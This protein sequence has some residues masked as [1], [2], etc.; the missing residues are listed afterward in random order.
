MPISWS[1][2]L[3]MMTFDIVHTKDD[4]Q[5]RWNNHLHLPVSPPGLVKHSLTVAS[6]LAACV[7][8]VGLLLASL[9]GRALKEGAESLPLWRRERRVR[10]R[11]WRVKRMWLGVCRRVLG[12]W[13]WGRGCG[14]GRGLA[15][16]LA[17]EDREG[18]LE[19]LGVAV[20][21]LDKDLIDCFHRRGLELRFWIRNPIFG[22][23]GN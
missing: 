17:S 9:G 15:L 6:H 5:V 10:G 11:G 19:A 21:V 20:E 18:E 2:K 22:D 14:R 13:W 16:G 12:F 7:E 8:V 1:L 4:D 23:G 3:E